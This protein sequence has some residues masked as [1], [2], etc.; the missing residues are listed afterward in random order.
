MQVFHWSQPVGNYASLEGW[1]QCLHG[2]LY[3]PG[4]S[5]W[6]GEISNMFEISTTVADP[7]IR[8]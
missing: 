7:C 5:L 4:L 1:D 2:R 8:P 6:V 3:L